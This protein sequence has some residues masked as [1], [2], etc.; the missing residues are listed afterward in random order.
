MTKRTKILLPGI[1][2]IVIGVAL[3][4]LVGKRL[5]DALTPQQVCNTIDPAWTASGTWSDAPSLI[6]PRAETAAAE[7]NGQIYMAGGIQVGWGGVTA[8]EV[9]DPVNKTWKKAAPLPA[10]L[11]HI[12]L[13]GA[14]NRI[15]LIGGYDDIVKMVK[16]APDSSKG[17]YYDPT[18]DTWTAIKDMPA[19][20]AAHGIVSLRDRIYIVAGTGTGAQAV[21]I[22]DP[23]TDSWDTSA[24]GQLP[25]PREHVS[26]FVINDKIYVVGGRWQYINTPSVEVYDPETD[27]WEKRHDMPLGT[28]GYMGA[29]VDGK[30]HILGGE[31]IDGNCLVAAHQIYDPVTDSWTLAGDFPIMRHGG[32]SVVVDGRWYVLGGSRKVGDQADLTITENVSLYTPAAGNG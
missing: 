16:A 31:N 25:T 9:F 17:W 21:W 15:Y 20:R 12:G 23:K 5:V 14:L 18:G 30:I 10:G 2:L 8:F 7:L 3:A 19:P 1:A 28:S 11:H 27:T 32:G 24:K 4:L 29:V 22:Y 6:T 13:V 26:A